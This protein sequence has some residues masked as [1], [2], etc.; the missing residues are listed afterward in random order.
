[1]GAIRGA[2]T[3]VNML[4]ERVEISETEDGVRKATV[5]VR[6]EPTVI[7]STIPAVTTKVVDTKANNS[8]S[9]DKNNGDGGP[10]GI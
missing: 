10:G 5:L 4:V 3:L 1:M 2:F 7:S 9:D 8:N 6:F